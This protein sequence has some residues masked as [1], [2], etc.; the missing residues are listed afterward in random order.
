[1][2][3]PTKNQTADD[4]LLTAELDAAQQRTLNRRYRAGELRRIHPGVYSPLPEADWPR[5]VARERNRLLAALFPG[6]VFGY[7]S[8]FA[9][10]VPDEG[11]V[12]LNYLYDRKIELPGLKV[13]LVKGPGKA[14]G[15]VSISGRELYFP[16]NPRV[17]LENLTISRGAAPKS[18]GQEAVE[19]RLLT[20]CE[21]RG[22]EAL[23]QLREEARSLSGSLG[24]AREFKLL[25]GLIASMLGS[26]PGGK[27]SSARG[28]GWTAQP[29]PYDAERL[30]LFEK[31]AAYLRTRSFAQRPSVAVS[32]RALE[33]FAFLESYF[34]NF[35]EGT[36]FEV[37]EARAFVL[38]SRP[39]D[40]R[41]K[42]SHDI[43]GVFRQALQPAWVLQ[44]LA[45]GEAVLEQLKPRAKK[46]D[47]FVSVGGFFFTDTIEADESAV[48]KH[49]QLDGME[50]HLRALDAAWSQVPSFDAAALEAALRG[51]ADERGVK[52]A[53]LIHAV[54]VALTGRTASPGLFEVASLL[55]RDRTQARLAA[56]IRLISA[57]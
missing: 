1:M 9:G 16:S 46:L 40:N 48:A 14:A 53:T 15:D 52:A 30:A 25:D 8:A 31:L 32:P 7:R 20:L 13:V 39:I 29:L 22:E 2:R 18:V 3:L 49:L 24:M 36:E 38:E 33:H 5:L 51:L 47:D 17:L 41:P 10:G 6:A 55:G 11:A 21:S 44:T 35:I 12:Y 43:L 34:S 45:A 27:L 54:R 19:E 56:A 37:R 50:A 28:K 4:L 57:C 26:R 42:D 23:N